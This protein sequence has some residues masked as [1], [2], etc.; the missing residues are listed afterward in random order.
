VALKRPVSRLAVNPSAASLETEQE[1]EMKEYQWW[2]DAL[3]GKFGPMHENEPQPGCYRA[4]DRAGKMQ[5]VVIWKDPTADGMRPAM[6]AEFCGRTIEADRIW[7]FCCRNPVTESQ[8]KAFEEA[9]QW[10]DDAPVNR[11]AGIG[12]N[13]PI[14]EFEALKAEISGERE[15]AEELLKEPIETAEQAD[16]VSA[17]VRKMPP[18]SKRADTLRTAEKQ[19]Y[20][21]GGRAVDEK[22]R[23]LV[24]EPKELADKLR[25]H[26]QPYFDRLEAE[27]RERERQAMLAVREAERKAREAEEA[28]LLA[29]REEQARLAE[30]IARA[31]AASRE[32]SQEEADAAREEAER[33]AAEAEK[34]RAAREA[35][36]EKA[37]KA[38]AEAQAEAARIAAE[39]IQAGRTGAKTSWRTIITAKI[40]NYDKA[41]MALRAHPEMREVVQKLADKMTKAGMPVEGV[42]RVEERVVR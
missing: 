36:A 18:L 4:K 1:K 3:N 22:W 12:D 35:A 30:G 14:D 5:P 16:R 26:L 6:M 24:S 20:L 37:A 8:I 2:R 34:E 15:I 25:K 27:K 23:D 21:D 13:L 9:G 41:V 10:H 17:W 39:K 7:S 29:E 32:E 33:I 28:R 38:A 31:E 19:P 11:L 42:E 40:V